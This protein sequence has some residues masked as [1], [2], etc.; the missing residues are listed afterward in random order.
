MVS[1]PQAAAM[2]AATGCFT[3][4]SSVCTPLMTSGMHSLG[5][6]VMTMASTGDAPMSV[7]TST[8]GFVRAD[9]RDV[10]AKAAPSTRPSRQPR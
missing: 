7:D 4:R 9:S 5:N 3:R 10:A 8:E 6:T 1:E 2:P